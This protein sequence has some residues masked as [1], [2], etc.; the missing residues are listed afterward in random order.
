MNKTRKILLALFL[1]M[2][3]FSLITSMLSQEKKKTETNQEKITTVKPKQNEKESTLQ[4]KDKAAITKTT[5]SQTDQ[6]E[7]SDKGQDMLGNAQQTLDRA[8]GILSIVATSLGC[9]IGLLA[10]ISS[11]VI[12]Y[13]YFQ[14]K[15]WAILRKEVN[16]EA[17]Y[18]RKIRKS[19]HRQ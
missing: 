7:E 17:V 1:I 19:F 9:T 12:T 6:K 16:E 15:K 5:V 18:I 8:V 4:E 14:F 10:I 2:L 11:I 3:S 13:I